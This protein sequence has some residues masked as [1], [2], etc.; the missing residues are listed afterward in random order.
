MCA[1]TGMVPTTVDIMAVTHQMKTNPVLVRRDV[2][3][4]DSC[5][6]R[7]A[8]AR[9]KEI[10]PTVG[11]ASVTRVRQRGRFFY[12]RELTRPERTKWGKWLE[13]VEMA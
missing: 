9:G 6:G 7:R 5:M 10:T 13:G 1:V 11:S 12:E 8:I 3:G 2:I 4:K